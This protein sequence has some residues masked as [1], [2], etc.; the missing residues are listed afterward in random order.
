MILRPYFGKGP[1]GRTKTEQ[2]GRMYSCN[3]IQQRRFIGKTAAGGTPREKFLA[4]CQARPFFSQQSMLV[5]D[6]KSL[7]RF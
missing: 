6:I 4:S 2:H 3:E 5:H 7:A 1:F